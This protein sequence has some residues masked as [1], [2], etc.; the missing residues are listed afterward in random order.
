[1][2]KLLIVLLVLVS[3][4]APKVVTVPTV[5][6][7]K[8]P[9][10]TQPTV[11]AAFANSPV[12]DTLSRGWAYLQT[13]DLKTARRE[14]SNALAA[15]PA[16][17]P[18]ETSLGYVELAQ[19]DANAALPHFD[20]AL[21]RARNDVPALLGRGQAL[22]ALNR[23]S[24]ARAAF[25]AALAADP[26]LSD[27][28]RRVEVLTFRSI[29]QTIAKARQLARQGKVD[30]A[31]EAYT[32]AIGNSP[33]SPFLYREIAALERQKGNTEAALADFRKAVALDSS[34]ARSLAQIGEILETRN[35]LDGA[36]KAYNDS[37]ALEP[38]ADLEKR[39]D[40]VRERALMEK[41][42][43]EYR[44][45]DQAPQVTR[46]DLAA[47]IGIKLAPLLTAR[48]DGVL[49]TD[50]RNH[51][52]ASWILAVARAGVM[53]PYANHAFQ[54]RTV[55]RRADLAQIVARLL[56][57]IGAQHP[58]QAKVWTSA[59]MTFS[60]L[61]ASHLAYVPASAA[62][63]AGV[64]TLAPESAFQPARPV[65]GAEAIEAVAKLEALAG[66]PAATRNKTPQ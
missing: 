32:T 61:P 43:P 62:V 1:M 50:T 11:P 31:L 53:E 14:F 10:F 36:E 34:D 56:T 64:L 58:N 24:D 30:E 7:P 48:R 2:R 63:A 57:K 60:D 59:R 29:E 9:D 55:V 37:L 42:P 45:L 4:C 18:A 54:P 17:Y 19:K 33:D 23:E 13:G 35:D 39:R 49:I 65:T 66:L 6:T 3:A 52:A 25:E 15:S 27:V 47:L 28:R 21:E 44:A 38:N 46:G 41:L 5:T 12:A 20:R 16:F 22:V 51:W 26:S 8:Y 40:A